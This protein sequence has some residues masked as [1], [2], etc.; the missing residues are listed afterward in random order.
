MTF[1]PIVERELRLAS[2]RGR[3]YWMRLAAAFVAAVTALGI[4]SPSLR[5]LQ[6]PT[7]SGANIFLVLSVGA[8]PLCL[9]GGTFI[10][11]DCMSE[12][13][14]EG[15]LG[16]LFLTELDSYDIV[17]GKLVAAS[18]NPFYGLIAALPV[19]ALPLMLGGVTPGE[20][21]RMAL[22]LTN[23]LFF[24][25][26]AGMFVSAIA[27]NGHKA[28]AGTLLLIL[29][30]AMGPMV[31]LVVVP[32]PA[33]ASGVLALSPG[34][35]CFLAFESRFAP[36]AGW[37]WI[38]N[39]LT[40]LLAWTLL[41]LAA[42]VLP[43]FWQDRPVTPSPFWQ[44]KLSLLQRRRSHWKAQREK[45]LSVNPVLWL[46]RRE[47]HRYA[48]FWCFL[49]LFAVG[50]SVG[51]WQW[52]ATWLRG[53]VVFATMFVLH[54]V[55]KCWLALE[56]S[57]RF[58]DSRRSGELELLLV[59]PLGVEN[60]LNG[61]ML[62]LK[63]QFLV[64]IT[65]VV[66]A[67][68]WLL[69]FCMNTPGWWANGETWALAFLASGALFLADSYTLSWTGL[70]HGLTARNPTQAFMKTLA[71]VLLL[72]WL[73]YLA[74]LAVLGPFFGTGGWVILWWVM[75]GLGTCLGLCNWANNQLQGEFREAA[76]ESGTP[77][78]LSLAW[79]RLLP[80]N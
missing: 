15:T 41:I 26:A 66:G 20:F 46:A 55:I 59:T 7:V 24:S 72:P 30:I 80:A 14:R 53:E 33:P 57:R 19:L 27:R 31:S 64:P 35:A 6:S 60:I 22:V 12:E 62:A 4:L 76:T 23:T 34:Y 52:R 58:A 79:R 45:L 40:H 77:A 56:A 75:V 13:K 38:S 54:L 74:T 43:R 65:V 5:G 49:A 73:I 18:L 61:R 39:L 17:L 42:R 3:T 29:I 11:A 37:F 25:L 70:W 51:Y 9:L 28:V 44:S 21:W 1:L 36:A 16:M 63:R 47:R 69:L 48:L 10:T 8:F 67:D 32:P 68:V 71:K 50:W 78:P 2:R